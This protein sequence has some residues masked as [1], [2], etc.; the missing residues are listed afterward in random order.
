MVV[1]EKSRDQL[2]GFIFKLFDRAMNEM[3]DQMMK[4]GAWP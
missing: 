1:M 2:I 3:K 4:D